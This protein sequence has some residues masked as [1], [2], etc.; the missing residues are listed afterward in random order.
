MVIGFN[1]RFVEP[2]LSGKKIHTI[3]EDAHNRWKVGMKMHMATGVRT[4]NYHQFDAKICKSIQK[5]E[6]I[7]TGYYLEEAMVLIDGILL[8]EKEI[9]QLAL[10]DGFNSLVDFLMWFEN[11][12]VGKII[13]WTDLKY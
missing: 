2:I 13:H 11:G 7:K 12:F 3:R 1:N 6:I 8:N 4:K 5:I 9:Q 10:N